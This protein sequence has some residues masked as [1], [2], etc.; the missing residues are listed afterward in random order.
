MGCRVRS[1]GHG[2]L[3]AGEIT[4]TGAL[5]SDCAFIDD[6]RVIDSLKSTLQVLNGV[7]HARDQC[8]TLLY[9]SKAFVSSYID[10]LKAQGQDLNAARANDSY[11]IKQE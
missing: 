3:P 2:A 7:E 9:N 5:Q 1:R 6:A 10:D 4:F 8:S 11:Y